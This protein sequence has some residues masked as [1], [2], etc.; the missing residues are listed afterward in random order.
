[1]N[2][3][4]PAWSLEVEDMLVFRFNETINELKLS[5]KYNPPVAVTDVKESSN[6]EV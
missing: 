2:N 3:D 4:E 1:M 6:K 5:D